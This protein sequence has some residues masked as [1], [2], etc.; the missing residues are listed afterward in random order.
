[1]RIC[2]LD[3]L[4]FG[5]FTD[6][7]LLFGDGQPG[8]HIVCGPNEAGKSSS[9][10]ALRQLLFGIPH[11]CSDAFLHS[12][13][14]LRIGARL[15]NGAG[16][17]LVC[18]R[19]KGRTNTLRGPDDVE[20]IDAMQLKE[21]LGGIDEETFSQR[22]GI[23]YEELR[24]GGQAVV[25]GGGDLGKLLFAAGAGIADLGEV[26]KS[27]AKDADELFK[28]RGSSQRINQSL[29]ELKNARGKIKKS[30][31]LTSDWVSHDEAL[32]QAAQRIREIDRQLK[33]KKT[34]HCRLER[35]DDALPVIAQRQ[36]LREQLTELAGVPLLPEDFS[37][38]RRESV[39]KLETGRQSRDEAVKAIAKLHQDIAKLKLPEELLAHRSAI[40][41]LHTELGSYQ[42]AAKD[43]PGLVARMEQAEKRAQDTLRDLGR[44]PGLDKV[45]ELR[46]NRRQRQQIQFLAGDCKALL[47]KKDAADQALRKLRAEI[48]Q[49]ESQLAQIA[50]PRDAGEL[51]RAIHLV[52]KYGDLEQQRD[53]AGG[54]LR[55]LEI[56]AGIEL[57]KL[58][59][60]QGTLDDLERLPVP[61]IETVER[62]EHELTDADSARD[63]IQARLNEV[64][65]QF[66]Q[67]DEK[68][69]RLRLEQDVPTEDDLLLARRQRDAG[70]QFVLRDWRDGAVEG[71]PEVN[72]FIKQFAPGADL[73]GA[74]QAS[75]EAADLIGDRLR[76]EADRVAEKATLSA[77][78]EIVAR[79]LEEQR[80]ELM[81]SQQRLEQQQERWREEW[82]LLKIDPLSPREMR[83]WLNQH[84][85][86]SE[87]ASELRQRHN[88]V[89]EL[90]CSIQSQ[91]ASLAQCLT[92]LGQPAS[93]GD[94]TLSALLGRCEVVVDE[95][96]SA[97]RHREDLAKSLNTLRTRLTTAE[98]DDAEAGRAVNEWRCNWAAA[99]ELLGLDR[100]SEP[101][102]AN[103]VIAAIDEL[104][105]HIK[106]ADEARMRIEGIDRDAEE[107]TASVTRLL[108]ECATDLLDRKAD[109]AVADLYDRLAAASTAQTK[110]DGWNDQLQ[111]EEEKCKQASNRILHWETNINTLCQEA[112]CNSLI[113]LPEAESRS[114]KRRELENKML[115]VNQQLAGLTGG[116]SLDDFVDE[117]SQQ[118]AD[119]VKATIDGLSADIVQLEKEKSEVSETIGAERTE[120]RRMEGSSQAAQSQEQVE[121]LLARI[122]DDAEQ[123]VRL[124]LA[125]S[126]LSRS[127]ERFRGASQEPVLRRA[128]E[129]FG[130][131]TLGS[132]E[133]LRAD[134]DDQGHAVLVGVRPGSQ[135]IVGVE[136]MSDGTCDQ[137]YLALRLSIME[138]YLAEGEP[139]PFIVDDILI[140]FDDDRAVAALKALVRLAEHTQVVFFTHHEH[141]LRL[142]HENLDG[143]LHTHT[144]NHRNAVKAQVDD[145]TS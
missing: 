10:R 145:A 63:A 51:K 49:I 69:R 2:Q 26:Q 18:I 117:A 86:L 133:G 16:E 55:Q 72:G 134:Y 76:R 52:Q 130:E 32:R 136:G 79:R 106:D 1:M 128:S 97:A 47:G 66:R 94:E 114:A 67:L 61:A 38:N 41:R 75:I 44:E 126:V 99:V 40:T 104:F 89:K 84:A 144:L 101:L 53:Q 23:D 20:V 33:L 3:L 58:R 140:M 82:A 124:R 109:Q 138:S 100:E 122:R 6:V 115:A 135:R 46:I 123:Y 105:A 15:Q 95:I 60:W 92:E 31:L 93:K 141:I 35:I 129:L 39:A 88:V 30:Q 107:F 57:E 91:C 29:S 87:T 17:A 73:A 36:Q 45:E 9:L 4:A 83:S 90:E 54:L 74:F 125:S 108:S 127:I 11:N 103:S 8:L 137:L 80:E 48:L 142:A 65:E 25:Q 113:E 132:F 119:Q 42:K 120:L 85:A 59:L 131:L 121:Q 112:G 77:D 102:A 24:R 50:S 22:F 70:W 34:E 19:R 68:L 5:P 96:E 56:Q 62:F 81:R 98:Q 37:G 14:N 64:T 111:R 78:R 71:E 27:L 118:I 116:A 43:R 28:P 110:L 12:N 7:S 13:Q 143:L 21:M 139:I